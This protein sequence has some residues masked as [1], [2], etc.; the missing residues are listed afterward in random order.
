MPL[1]ND[2]ER[3]GSEDCP[4]CRSVQTISTGAATFSSRVAR[5]LM[6]MECNDCGS[7]WTDHYGVIGYD[8]LVIGDAAT[9]GSS[10]SDE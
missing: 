2:Q 8:D 1:M 5:L 3:A 10:M 9:P 6:P 7:T 4:N